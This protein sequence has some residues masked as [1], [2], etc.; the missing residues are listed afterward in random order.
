MVLTILSGPK[1]IAVQEK[2]MPPSGGSQVQ[3]EKPGLNLHTQPGLS[4]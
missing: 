1:A 3:N 4:G 2:Y